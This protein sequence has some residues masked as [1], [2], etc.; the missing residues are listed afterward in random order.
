[1]G[2]PVLTLSLDFELDFPVLG[3]VVNPDEFWTGGVEL[4]DGGAE[5]GTMRPSSGGIGK[6][7]GTV[8]QRWMAEEVRTSSSQEL[9]LG[10]WAAGLGQWSGRMSG[11]PWVEWL[12]SSVESYP[13][14]S[15][16]A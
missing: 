6:V 16:F 8:S 3:G 9:T 10:G 11:T 5:T 13:G 15:D 7:D 14:V 4:T 2:G 12:S 1:M